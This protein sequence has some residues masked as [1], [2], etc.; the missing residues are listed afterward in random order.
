MQNRLKRFSLIIGLIVLLLYALWHLFA[1]Q[2]LVDTA[3]SKAAE[4][5]GTEISIGKPKL[6]LGGILAFEKILVSKGKNLTLQLEKGQVKVKFFPLLRG[7]LEIRSFNFSVGTASLDFSVAKAD[8]SSLKA[9]DSTKTVRENSSNL[10]KL[11]PASIQKLFRLLPEEI[12]FTHLDLKVLRNTDSLQVQLDSFFFANEQLMAKI[13]LASS[14]GPVS[15][16]QMN[17]EKSGNGW[18]FSIKGDSPQQFLKDESGNYLSL[19]MFS[20]RMDALKIKED[21][22]SKLYLKLDSLEIWHPQ[23]VYRPVVFPQLGSATQL[24][25]S[26]HS[27]HLD[28]AFLQMKDFKLPFDLVLN[29][30]SQEEYLSL[31]IEKD[32]F[33]ASSFFEA[34]PE[35]L[36]LNFDGLQISGESRFEFQLNLPFRQL[37]SLQLDA[38]LMGRNLQI[39]SWPQHPGR[40]RGAVEHQIYEG[41]T[42]VKNVSLDTLDQG[43]V[44][45]D[46]ISPF[47]IYSVLTAEDG[48][49]FG[50]KG[51]HP[52]AFRDAMVANIK[53][54]YFARGGST[55]TM[56][57]VKNL[58][59]NRSKTISRKIEEMLIVWMIENMRLLS[60]ERML[61]IYFN[62]I[63][64][65]PGI[66]G[67]KE[68]SKFYFDKSPAEI[69]LSEALF[70][71][72]LVP[73]PKQYVWFFENESQLKPYFEQYFYNVAG[74]MLRREQID[75]SAWESITVDIS[76]L[77]KANERLV[78][79]FAK[80]DSIPWEED[81]IS[82]EEILPLFPIEL[83]GQ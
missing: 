47:L 83:E 58:Y 54:G 43:F 13:N 33:P 62:I 40:L 72:A 30:T 48:G 8:S 14:F 15:S 41:D 49:Y 63:E 67:V 55:I 27:L 69:T 10:E 65:G 31:S 17:A 73:R 44:R 80:N 51:F 78:K 56:Q 7:R 12:K 39:K 23:L 64:W 25:V 21:M 42:F 2:W 71:S 79:R 16:W 32:Y 61:E 5:T 29:W 4:K 26:G 9:S 68:A 81:T 11:S 35:G 76:L 75:S 24:K 74:H 70:M 6:K 22:E 52:T 18:D 59:L 66:Y 60:K 28:Q 38:S 50:H 19:K 3:I 36:F 82:E 45:L 57:L 1:R 37:D 46:Q 34:L 77:G 53:A 20:M